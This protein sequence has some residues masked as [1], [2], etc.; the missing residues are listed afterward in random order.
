M[1]LSEILS[2]PLL[3]DECVTT[4]VDVKREIDLGAISMIN[5]KTARTGYFQS[6][7]VIHLVEQAG[8]PCLIGTLLETD[9]GVLASAHF[10]AAFKIFSYP[11]ELTYFLKMEDHLLKSPLRVEDG[12]LFLPDRP[13]LGMELDEGKL[14]HYRVKE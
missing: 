12:V 4:P 10:G 1:K 14:E 3:G 11:A 6:R 5:V 8:F 7:K 9:I 13:G 2:V